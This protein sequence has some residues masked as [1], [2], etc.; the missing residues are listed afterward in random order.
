MQFKC[1]WL[2][3]SPDH[4]ADE[5]DDDDLDEAADAEYYSYWFS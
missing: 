3:H 5:C 4:H 1:F 2:S